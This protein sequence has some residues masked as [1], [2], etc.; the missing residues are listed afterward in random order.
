[1]FCGTPAPLPAPS[2]PLVRL[3]R[4]SHDGP[5]HPH[6]TIGLTGGI[7]AG[8]STVSRRLRE[9][10]ATVVDADA[11][12]RDLQRPGEAGHAAIRERF[13]DAVIDPT[14]G[15]LLR[16]ALARIVFGDSEQLEALNAIMHPLIR[17]EAARLAAQAPR[18]GVV[19]HDLPLLVE[20]GQHAD[21]DLVVTVQAPLEERV[22]R[23]RAE[24]GMSEA[25]ARARIAAQ[26]DDAARA[27]VSD[28]VLHN[29]TDRAAFL[30]RIDA[31][32]DDVVLPR[33]RRL[34][35]AG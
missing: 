25:E 9:L 30:G 3:R 22:R 4:V 1:M 28:V 16:P 7:A 21:F 8:K 34:G 18:G 12:A 6:L 24:R 13:G 11:V 33:A 32:W 27:A 5:E 29:D 2:A 35:R 19:V 20:T 31:F 15:E 26:V 23:M 10:G 14:T 17:R